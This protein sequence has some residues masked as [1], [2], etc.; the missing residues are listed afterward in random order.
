MAS[1]PLANALLPNT[2]ISESEVVFD[3]KAALQRC[4]GNIA[5]L[6]HHIALLNGEYQQLLETLRQCIARGD[7]RRLRRAAY[8]LG[9]HAGNLSAPIV[10]ESALRLESIGRTGNLR[11]A[12]QALND[13][14]KE[15]ERLR[16]AIGAIY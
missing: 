15:L 13:L 4:G 3:Q 2:P 10:L 14:E 7:A 8:K 5:S 11:E 1:A 6:R 9:W 16:G 12:T